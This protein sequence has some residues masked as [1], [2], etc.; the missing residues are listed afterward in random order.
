MILPYGQPL[1]RRTPKEALTRLGSDPAG[2]MNNGYA[3]YKMHSKTLE[4]SGDH[5]FRGVIEKAFVVG[6]EESH[7]GTKRG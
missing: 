4:E 1:K 3:V 7:A 2:Q 6:S 5:E